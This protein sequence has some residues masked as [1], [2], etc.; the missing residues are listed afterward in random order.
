MSEQELNLVDAIQIALEAEKQSAAM[1]KEAAE[2]AKDSVIKDLFS[3]LSSFE[4]HHYE[5]V[6]ELADSLKKKGKFVV[7]E[8]YSLPIPAQS[9][10]PM[11]EE[12]KKTLN[13]GKPSMMSVLTLAQEVEAQAVKRYT[14]MGEQTDDKEGKKMFGKLAQEEQQHL[15]LM[16]EV[17]WNVNNRGIWAWSGL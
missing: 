10:I 16:T 5:K 13:A 7:Y 14:S 6:N 12:A 2:N 1:Y 15:T 11:S 9:E 17:Y 3:S 4:Q 8:G